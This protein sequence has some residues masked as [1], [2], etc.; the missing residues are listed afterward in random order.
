MSLWR[1]SDGRIRWLV[2]VGLMYVMSMIV[3][4]QRYGASSLRWLESF[5]FS[6]ACLAAAPL[7][8]PARR[9]WTYRRKLRT[10]YGLLSFALFVLS[11][12][13]FL[14]RAIFDIFSSK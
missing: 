5:S 1:T 2:V 4:A 12:V 14:R 13:L 11:V 8:E 7:E 9:G 3:D 10:W 6:V